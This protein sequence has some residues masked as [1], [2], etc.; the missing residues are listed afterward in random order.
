M[1]GWEGVRGERVHLVGDGRTDS[2]MPI[3]YNLF[4]FDLRGLTMCSLLGRV[5]TARLSVDGDVRAMS[6][7]HWKES[8][9]LEDAM[10]VA[11]ITVS[12]ADY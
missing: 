3:Y 5:D 1:V 4:L 8:C 7:A 12:L 2:C 11:M 9:G 6:L 10:S